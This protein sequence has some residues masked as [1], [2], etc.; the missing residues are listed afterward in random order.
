[1]ETTSQKSGVLSKKNETNSVDN[2]S[3]HHSDFF[4]DINQ[5]TIYKPFVLNA[6]LVDKI[7]SFDWAK[8]LKETHS[9]GV[10]E[11]FFQNVNHILNEKKNVLT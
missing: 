3:L 11:T 9:R 4:E 2:N 8:Y 10:P 5:I 1:M 6:G 7:E